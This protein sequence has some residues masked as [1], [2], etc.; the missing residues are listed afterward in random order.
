MNMATTD[1]NDLLK[2]V[3]EQLK[4]SDVQEVKFILKDKFEGKF[5]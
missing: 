1:I 4:P 3:V 2:S 5:C